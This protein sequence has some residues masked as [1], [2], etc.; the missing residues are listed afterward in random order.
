MRRLSLPIAATILAAAGCNRDYPNPFASSNVTATPPPSA[1]IVYTSDAPM[2]GGPREVYAVGDDGTAPTR[3]TFCSGSGECDNV[4]L[5]PGPDRK[6]VVVRRRAAAGAN[7]SLVFLDLSRGVEGQ[8]LPASAQV[9]G[10]DWSPTDEILV[11]S[12]AGEGGIEDLYRMDL[13]GQNQRPLTATAD[14]RERRPRIDSTGS[15]AAY[16]R[17]AAGGKAEIWIFQSSVNQARITSGGPGSDPLPGTL[18]LVGSDAD[19]EFSPDGRSVVFRRLTGTGN[20]GLG[21][22]DLLTTALDGSS[23]VVIASGPVY[24][25]AADWSTKGIVFTEIDNA[26]RTARLVVVQPD[27]SGR[28]VPVS[29]DGGRSISFPRWLR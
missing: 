13:N 20:G 10:I 5:A 8:L 29:L 9:S 3:L 1:T 28:K 21:T 15:V 23:P 11:Y 16:E 14:L 27:G 6:R 7:E 25:G 17:I 22:W 19:P 4:E 26:T 18:Y 2:A 24:R 12:A